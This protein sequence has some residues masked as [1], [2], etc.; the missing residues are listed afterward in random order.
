M[1]ET[2]R[3]ADQLK[4]AVYG[5]AWSGPSVKEVLEGVSAAAAS[6]RPV[7]G[8]HSIWELV[9]HIGAWI[10]IARRRVEGETVNV[11]PEVNFPPVVDTSEEAWKAALK[12]LEAEEEALR[13]TI[14]RLSDEQLDQPV[15]PS[16]LSVYILLHGAIQ[17]SLYHAGQIPLLRKAASGP[18]SS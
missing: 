6:A 17:H 2:E 14:R 1:K 12:S 15:R 4:R 11:T 3:I 9:L 8:A 7:A 18:S 10:N 13:S 16:G 5:E